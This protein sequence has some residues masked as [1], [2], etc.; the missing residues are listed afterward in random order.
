MRCRVSLQCF[1]VTA[2]VCAAQQ[3]ALATLTITCEPIGGTTV[4]GGQVVEVECFVTTDFSQHISGYRLDFACSLPQGVGGAGSMTVMGITPDPDGEFPLGPSSDGTLHLFFGGVYT[5]N[6]NLCTIGVDHIGII[7]RVLLPGSRA[8]LATV[9]Y[10]VS[11]CAAG[12]FEFVFE[13]YSNPPSSSDGTSFQGNF[14]AIPLNFTPLTFT[15]PIGSCC[16]DDVCAETVNEFCCAQN[17]PEARWFEGRTCDDPVPCP[18]CLSDAEC[19]DDIECTIDSCNSDTGACVQL[20]NHAFCDDGLF[21]NGQETCD[22]QAGCAAGIDP[23]A[24]GM[25]CDEATETC[26]VPPIPT[27]SEWG[28]VILAL[29]LVTG[30]KANRS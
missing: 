23:C 5:V 6:L 27:I 30:A 3:Q 18:E 2:L 16:V 4:T 21:C 12:N 24:F 10:L 20:A 28:L 15:V 7:P 19:D 26:F 13:N 14:M 22:L 25:D 9:Y 29:L 8:Y 11:D 1:V 17:D